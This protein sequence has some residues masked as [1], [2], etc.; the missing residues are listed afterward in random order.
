MNEYINTYHGT[1]K[2]KP[3]DVTDNTYIYSSKDVND[4]D[5][6]FQVGDH[7]GISK[8]R[9]IFTKG[10]TPNLSEVFVINKIKNTVPQTC[11]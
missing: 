2:M 4:K 3:I 10:Y 11:Y 5:P 6:K 8:Y 7:V 9:N 1:I